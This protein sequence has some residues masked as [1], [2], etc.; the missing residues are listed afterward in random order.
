MSCRELDDDL[1]EYNLDEYDKT[2]DDEDE[3]VPMG[4]FGNVKSLAYHDA[5]ADDPY[6]TL[7]EV[8][9]V[10]FYLTATT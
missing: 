10:A 3:G 9:G 4:M 8:G 2:D 5:N 1:K 6:I 7:K